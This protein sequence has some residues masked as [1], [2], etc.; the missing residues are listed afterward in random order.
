MAISITS[1]EGAYIR[2]TVDGPMTIY[3]ASGNKTELL[4]ALA[5][6]RGLEIDLSNVDEIDTAGLQLLVLT[7][8][9]GGKVG[10]PVRLVAQSAALLEVLNRYGLGTCFDD[11]TAPP[12]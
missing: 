1:V 11:P 6:G 8:R 2:L 3:E 4:E 7:Q 9:E 10:K 5:D 12:Q